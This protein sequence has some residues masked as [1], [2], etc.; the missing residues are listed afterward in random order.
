MTK[1]NPEY[2][3][4][5]ANMKQRQKW[6]MILIHIGLVAGTFAAYEPVR[7]NVFLE[8]YDDR[9][10]VTNNPNVTGGITLDSAVWA[11]SKP[12]AVNWHPLTSL[13]HIL[14]CEIYGLNPAGH[15]MTSV[16]IHTANSMLLFFV[17][18]KMTGVVWQSAFVA[19]IFAIHP[20]QVDSVA[21][22]SERKT[23][24]SGL[25]WLLT[26]AAYLRYAQQPTT[27]RY[28]WVILAYALCIMTKP[29]VV[30]LPFAL[31]L[32]DYWPLGRVKWR[33]NARGIDPVKRPP[34][35]ADRRE[36]PVSRLVIEKIPL[37]VL[38][39]I[40]CVITFVVQKGEGAVI[41]LEEIPLNY[42]IANSFVSYVK[43]IEKTVWPSQ[44]AALYPFNIAGLSPAVVVPC[45]VIFLLVSALCIYA[46][47]RRRYLAVGWL[48]YVGTLVPTIGL[49]QA[50]GQAMA[51]R[52]MYIP[53]IGLLIIIVWG[54]NDLTATWRHRG[55]FLALPAAAVLLCAIVLTRIQVAYWRDDITLFKHTLSV[56]ENNAVVEMCYG[57]CLAEAGR[58]DEGLPHLEKAVRISP[59]FFEA[60]NKLGILYMRQGKLDEAIKCFTKL[61]PLKKDSEELHYN[62]ALALS[63]QKRY[64]EAIKHFTAVLDLNPNY[65]DTREK[66]GIVLLA[67]GRTNEAIARFNEALPASADKVN[68]YTNLGTA[69]LIQGNNEMAIQSWTKALQ[70]KPDNAVNL[71]NLAWLLATREEVSAED[72]NKA[73]RFAEDACKLTGYKEPALLD[74][75]AAAYAAAGRFDD[76]VAI[77]NKAIDVARAS[78]KEFAASRIQERLK[79]YQAGRRYQGKMPSE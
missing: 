70:L 71:N 72:A 13:S 22:V 25:L 1:M 48:W 51:N 54:I 46:G 28:L 8:Y 56:T 74:T 34:K 61:L 7:D 73:V 38:S 41:A 39:A 69:Y 55:K 17:L 35:G 32:L 10:Y 53:I 49:V 77:A 21:W 11:F 3:L 60:R 27:R 2:G 18:C 33:R 50:G 37:F 9:G 52:Y 16:L 5:V 65:F 44:L 47:R 63:G 29:I 40:L 26:I 36:L 42:R 23:V 67:A 59:N 12:H 4:S 68:I 6:V 15:H 66:M 76:A 31:L 75:L 20:L 62:L 58:A 14:D 64:D 19:A 45:A 78:G 43:Y 30:T 79:L 57:C 24:L